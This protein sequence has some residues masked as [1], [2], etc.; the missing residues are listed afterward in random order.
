MFKQVNPVSI[1]Q[2]SQP[3]LGELLLSSH[4]SPYEY[5]PSEQFTYLHDSY[6]L[7]SVSRQPINYK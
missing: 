1:L 7:P 5:T 3:S 6:N 4:Y 2:L